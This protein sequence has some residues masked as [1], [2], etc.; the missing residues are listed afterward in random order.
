MMVMMVVVVVVVEITEGKP[1]QADNDGTKNKCDLVSFSRPV[2]L[3][4]YQVFESRPLM[5]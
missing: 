5:K 1:N 3:V 4:A 2:G